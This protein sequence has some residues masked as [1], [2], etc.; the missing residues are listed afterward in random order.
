MKFDITHST[1]CLMVV[2]HCNLFMQKTHS[3]KRCHS[4]HRRRTMIPVPD[5]KIPEMV[6]GCRK[7]GNA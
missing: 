6:G 5:S 2:S 4:R 1:V 7:L 3:T